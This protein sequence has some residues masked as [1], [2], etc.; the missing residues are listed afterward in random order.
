[1]LQIDHFIERTSAPVF[2]PCLLENMDLDWKRCVWRVRSFAN[3]HLANSLF[4][5]FRIIYAIDKP[6]SKV[7]ETMVEFAC[8]YLIK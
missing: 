1:M 5:M 2:I 6:N 8:S 7:M 3:I 4:Y